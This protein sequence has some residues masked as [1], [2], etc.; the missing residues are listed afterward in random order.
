MHSSSLPLKRQQMSL[1]QLHGEQNVEGIVKSSRRTLQRSAI[2][3]KN[4][5]EESET[6]DEFFV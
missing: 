2:N 4:D 3:D 5:G 6:G 1:K